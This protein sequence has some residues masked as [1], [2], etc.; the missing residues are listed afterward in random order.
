[1]GSEDE[2][3]SRFGSVKQRIF[4]VIG[5]VLAFGWPF[6]VA[7]VYP[8]RGNPLGS[9][10]GGLRTIVAEWSVVVILAAIAFG[11][12]GSRPAMFR[13]HGFGRTDIR[14]LIG[15]FVV[16]FVFAGAVSRLVAAP[17]VD[18]HQITKIPLAVRCVL[19]VTAAVCEEFMFRG[20]AIEEIGALTGSRW[21]GAAIS[22]VLFGL[23]HVGLYGF[24]T[25]LLIPMSIGLVI[26]LL[27]MFRNN[28]PICMLLHGLI[29]G[30]SV[31]VVPAFSHVR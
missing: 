2:V 4:A 23:G 12:Q 31:I 14:Y 6:L 17:K 1:M 13:F 5:V 8:Q 3:V 16:A 29:D 9:T 25:A 21:G 10:R 15:A 30:L 20:F 7:V 27:Y 11:L 26:T 24:S 22:V 28:L 19:V 18:L